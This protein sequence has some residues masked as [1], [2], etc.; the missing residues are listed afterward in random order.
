MRVFTE[1][2]YRLG[3]CQ[4]EEMGKPW[5]S[6]WTPLDR[7]RNRC[8]LEQVGTPKPAGATDD[9]DET[10][11][12]AAPTIEPFRPLTRAERRRLATELRD[13]ILVQA[14]GDHN[15]FI[16]DASSQANKLLDWASKLDADDTTDR[17]LATLTV[18]HLERLPDSEYDAAL[19]RTLAQTSE[20]VQRALLAAGADPAAVDVVAIFRDHVGLTPEVI[21]DML[22][23]MQ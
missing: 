23:D 15:T 3:V 10:D 6:R 4:L 22:A 7:K 17:D 1:Y 14:H 9:A 12:D 18:K 19:V 5:E 20:A 13:K 11:S 21:A 2:D 16:A 8:L